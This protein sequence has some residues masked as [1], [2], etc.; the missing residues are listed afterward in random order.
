MTKK[1]HRRRRA[2]VGS[3]T[4]I[5]LLALGT[6][7]SASAGGAWLVRDFGPIE[8][9]FGLSEFTRVGDKLLFVGYDN[10]HGYEL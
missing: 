1:G 5:A 7:P 4:A 2:I 8:R 10:A 9:G 6:A 3:L